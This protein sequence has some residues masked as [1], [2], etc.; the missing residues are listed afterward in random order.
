MDD[1]RK[2]LYDSYVSLF[3]KPSE[4]KAHD[5]ARL[6][7]YNRKNFIGLISQ[8]SK[9]VEILDLGCGSGRLLAA[10]QGDGW[11][12]AKGI[13]VSSEQIVSAV[14]AGIPAVCEDAFE[15]LRKNKGRYHIIFAIDF[16]EHFSRDEVL[17]LGQLIFEG[18]R[19]GGFL[20]IQTPNGK[21]PFALRNIYGDLTHL[22]IFSDESIRQ[23]L[24]GSG[25]THI[26]AE[27]PSIV[28]L[29]WKDK[30]RGFLRAVII[31][32]TRL[33]Y[34]IVTSRREKNIGENL[35][36]QAKKPG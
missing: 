22:C 27:S 18:L 8:Y 6:A 32:L 19:P 36:V 26:K 4:N 20:I 11:F 17:T 15:Y 5:G 24:K 13:D 2:P 29:G 25:F 31:T 30:I 1:F 34:F 16:V 23:W 21:S 3:K 33:I 12:N 7:Q 28:S 9:D 14:A 10:L 35:L